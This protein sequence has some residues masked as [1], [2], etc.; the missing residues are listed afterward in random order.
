[1]NTYSYWVSNDILG[2][3]IELPLVTPEQV[4]AS[5]NFKYIFT[6]RLEEPVFKNSQF[7]GQEKHLV[8]IQ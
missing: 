8:K 2:K 5:R 1:M 4:A 7:K 6:G 3:W